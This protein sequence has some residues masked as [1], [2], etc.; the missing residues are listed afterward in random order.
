MRT[1]RNPIKPI[2]WTS[3]CVPRFR[4]GGWGGWQ[5]ECVCHMFVLSSCE[6]PTFFWKIPDPWPLLLNPEWH[7]DLNWPSASPGLCSGTPHVHCNTFGTFSPVNL[8]LFVRLLAR[9]EELRQVGGKLFFVL[10]YV[11]SNFL[12]F[13]LFLPLKPSHLLLL[14][15]SFNVYLLSDFSIPSSIL[16]SKRR[17][18]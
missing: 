15:C 2:C 10:L 7:I 4:G 1:G 6:L 8:F 18:N 9:P 11:D 16:S 5:L 14:I 17:S 12:L 3:L 13:H